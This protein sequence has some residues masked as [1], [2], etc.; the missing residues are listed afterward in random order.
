MD[1]AYDFPTMNYKRW[2]DW[3]GTNNPVFPD[4]WNTGGTVVA[5]LDSFL[6]FL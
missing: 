4:N 1:Y 2:T 5:S 6:E 3:W